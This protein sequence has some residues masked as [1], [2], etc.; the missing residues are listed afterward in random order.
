LKTKFLSFILASLLIFTIA[1]PAFASSD[2]VNADYDFDNQLFV[3]SGDIGDG[4]HMVTVYVYRSSNGAPVYVDQVDS[5]SDG[6]YSASVPFDVLTKETYDI[7]VS[8]D[9]LVTYH[10]A[11]KF[12]NPELFHPKM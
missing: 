1:F 6:T 8:S 10:T 5:E 12:F 3:I 4:V 2:Y 9:N 7:I 11:S